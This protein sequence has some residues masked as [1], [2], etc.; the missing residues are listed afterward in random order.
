MTG[1][2]NKKI[3]CSVQNICLLSHYSTHV[4]IEDRCTSFWLLVDT[5]LVWCSVC[6][7]V[8]KY[9]LQQI[10]CC[11]MHCPVPPCSVAISHYFIRSASCSLQ[12][13]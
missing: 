12:N 6:S 8:T 3:E 1:I 4:K 2:F 7:V 11:A 9:S 13:I 5:E 10:E